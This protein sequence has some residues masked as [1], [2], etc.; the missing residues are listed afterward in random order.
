MAS[1]LN[2]AIA[3]G[4]DCQRQRKAEELKKA[5]IAAKKWKDEGPETLYKARKDYLVFTEG[6]QKY[7]ERMMEI[8]TAEATED[9]GTETRAHDVRMKDIARGNSGGNHRQADARGAKTTREN[10]NDRVQ[11]AGQSREGCPG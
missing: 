5:L 4:G 2:K 11:R 3:C 6:V 7:N 8:Y 10:P 1:T 9:A